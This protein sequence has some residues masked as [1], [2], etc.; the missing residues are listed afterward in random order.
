MIYV[1]LILF[2][3][4]AF[5]FTADCILRYMERIKSFDFEKRLFK[6]RFDTVPLHRFFPKSLTVLLVAVVVMS[7]FGS[8]L[9]LLG[10]DWYLS[11]PCSVG[12]G[13]L[14]CFVIQH[15]GRNAID[16]IKKNDLPQ[17]DEAAGLDGYCTQSIEV[18]GWGKVR[19]FHT[20]RSGVEREFEVNAVNANAGEDGEGDIEAGKKVIC[21]YEEGGFYFVVRV[22]KIYNEINSNF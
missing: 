22:D 5:A 10:M 17:G 15:L 20:G 19:L 3:I 16:R 2:V 9:L 4:S 12:G 21:V 18:G 11:V 7:A 1:Y 13:L 14:A 8:L 6:V